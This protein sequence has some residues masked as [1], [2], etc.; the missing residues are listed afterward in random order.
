[1]SPFATAPV[2][3]RHLWVSRGCDSLFLIGPL[4]VS[5]SLL[6]PVH[7]PATVVFLE[8]K[9]NSVSIILHPWPLPFLC[10]Q[11]PPMQSVIQ[12]LLTSPCY[13][14]EACPFMH[15]CPFLIRLPLPDS[16]FIFR[17]DSTFLSCRNLCSVNAT[18]IIYEYVPLITCDV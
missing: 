1:M 14:A 18:V 5:V 16:A 13:W 9:S 17:T 11:S 15:L 3:P 2:W 4:R 12:I 7:S 10:S 8:Q 6:S